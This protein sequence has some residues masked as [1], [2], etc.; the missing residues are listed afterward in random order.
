MKA[1]VI[2]RASLVGALAVAVAAMFIALPARVETVYGTAG[3]PDATMS[4]DGK[5][6]PAP[7]GKF[8]GVIK[9][10]AKDFTPYC[11]PRIVP[12]KGAPN[13]L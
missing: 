11:P 6:I 13:L 9:E 10:S 8:G 12:P 7:L 2:V 4:I 5:Q 1:R 3:S